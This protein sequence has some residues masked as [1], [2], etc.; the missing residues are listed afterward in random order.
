MD[1][2]TRR[3][4]PSNARGRRAAASVL[5]LSFVDVFALLPTVAPHVEGLGAGPAGIGLAVGAYSAANLPANVIGGILVDRRGRRPVLLGGLAAAA[6]AVAAYTL[7]GSVTTFVGAR[8]LH[9]AAGG[10]L[11]PA[12][13]A[14]AG[15]R[16]VSGEVGRTFGRLGATIG[17]AAVVAPPVAGVVRA[18][19]GADAVFLGVSAL[20]GLGVVIAAVAVHDRVPDR[21]GGPSR[22][23][24][25]PGTPPPGRAATGG[26]AR[27]GTGQP[28]GGMRALL[29]DPRMRRALAATVVLTC[30]VGV[31]AAFLPG[32]AESLGAAPASVGGLFGVYAVVAAL[33]MLSPVAGRVDRRGAD[34]PVAAGLLLLAAS[35][36]LLAT[37]GRL[38]LAW[39]AMAVFG[40][41]FG[42]LF[43]AVSAAT[44]LAS[45]PA[46]RGRAFGLFNVAY[47]VGLALGPPVVGLLVD[48][49]PSS[50]PFAAVAA[51]AAAGGI[52]FTAR[53]LRRPTAHGLRTRR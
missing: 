47:S 53:T 41:G 22:G 30:A 48:I 36:L 5:F 9:G 21:A 23:P 7:A 42:L 28:T 1:V 25:R 11:I 33:L 19:W 39:T 12:V 37:A 34:G 49:R 3:P 29:S 46:D 8:L 6:V 2:R 51:I 31:L 35:L 44:S 40:L 24:A 20:L 27:G 43:P 14:A 52:A 45:A 4:H 10:I 32:A 26:D 13:F 18:T 50:D 17:A 16:A 38:W 15:D